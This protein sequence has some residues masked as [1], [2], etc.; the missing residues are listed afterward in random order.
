MASDSRC[1]IAN[2][3]GR[4]PTRLPAR[5]PAPRE[6]LGEITELALH[7]VEDD[8]S[9]LFPLPRDLLDETHL[10]HLRDAIAV[11]MRRNALTSR[12]LVCARQHTPD[13]STRTD[14]QLD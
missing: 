11:A 12:R 13:V 6:A 4:M 9:D 8:E 7:H 10:E 3:T 5:R 14:V 2:P 1:P